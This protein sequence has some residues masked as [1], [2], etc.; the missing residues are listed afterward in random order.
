MEKLEGKRPLP[1]ILYLPIM[2]YQKSLPEIFF[3]FDRTWKTE[4]R[5]GK[6]H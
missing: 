6:N 3:F 2:N 5:K 4:T 1:I